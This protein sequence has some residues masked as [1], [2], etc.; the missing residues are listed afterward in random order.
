MFRMIV[1]ADRV[2]ARCR[3]HAGAEAAVG[4]LVL[5]QADLLDRFAEVVDVVVLAGHLRDGDAAA[6]GACGRGGRS[7]AMPVAS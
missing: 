5:L 3:L 1:S 7:V 2:P 6:A 4:D